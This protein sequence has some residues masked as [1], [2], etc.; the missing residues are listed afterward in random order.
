MLKFIRLKRLSS[1]YLLFVYINKNT[2]VRHQICII[3]L[4]NIE[5]HLVFQR[6]NLQSS[7]LSNVKPSI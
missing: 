3:N 6:F 1:N 7:K 4:F 5:T 2:S